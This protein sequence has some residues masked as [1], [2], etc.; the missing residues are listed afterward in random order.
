MGVVAFAAVQVRGLSTAVAVD[1]GSGASA[2]ARLEVGAVAVAVVVA[3]A[4]EIGQKDPQFDWEE[5]V[6][7]PRVESVQR[8]A[9]G[10]YIFL[11]RQ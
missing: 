5:L 10:I 3:V 1:Q 7:G 2:A 4:V 6:V 9:K 8:P 11:L